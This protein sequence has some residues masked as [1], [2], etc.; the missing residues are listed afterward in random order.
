MTKRTYTGINIQ[1]PITEL[2]LSGR[3]TIE[4]RTYHIPEKYL[5]QEMLMVETPG[6]KGKF[7]ARIVAI[8]KFTE[9]FEYKN[10]KEFY[11]D[12]KNHCVTP[13]SE[14]A[15]LDKKKFGWKIELIKKIATPIYVEVWT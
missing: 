1:W 2:I 8:I 15:W 13:D 12:S 4:T 6:K 3:K 7:K 10:K 5:N 9:C 11:K 14:W